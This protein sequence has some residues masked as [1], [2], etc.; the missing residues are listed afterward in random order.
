MTDQAFGFI[1]IGVAIVFVL[2]LVFAVSMRTARPVAEEVRVPPGVHLPAPS[3]LPVLV[4]LAGLLIGAG[5][6][7]RPEG[8]IANLWIAIPGLALFVYAVVRWVR[9]AGREWH[10][11]ELGPHDDARTH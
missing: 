8:A 10:D 11:V 1:L 2:G 3:A 5:L 6:A 9:D 4:A 7:F